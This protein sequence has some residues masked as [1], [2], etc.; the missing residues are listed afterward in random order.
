MKFSNIYY[1]IPVTQAIYIYMYTYISIYVY[2]VVKIIIFIVI[3]IA[4]L[5]KEKEAKYKPL[6]VVNEY[7]VRRATKRNNSIRPQ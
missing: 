2:S 4:Y 5:V 6:L 3:I 7:I 1:V